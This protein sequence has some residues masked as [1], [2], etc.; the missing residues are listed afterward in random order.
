MRSV[1]PSSRATV[2]RACQGM[3]AALLA[4][5]ALPA[6]AQQPH[7]VQALDLPW[8]Q[9]VHKAARD[10]DYS[11]V[12]IYTQGQS[13]Q[14]MKLVHVVD[15]TGERERLEIMDGLPREFLRQNE[16]T[17][18]LLPEKKMVVI[19]RRQNERFPSFLVGDVSQLPQHYDMRRLPEQERVAGRPCDVVELVP[20]D[21]QR[22]GYRLC[23]DTDHRLLLRM[24]TVDATQSVVDQIAFASVSF[25]DQVALQDLR[26]SWNASQWQVVEPEVRQ[27]QAS[28]QGWV[29]TMPP[30]FTMHSEMLRPMRAGRQVTHLVMAD[31]LAAIS[32]FLERVGAPEAEE[33][34]L[35][36]YHRGAMNMF[37]TRIN[38]YVLTTT[39]EVPMPT[40]RALA[41]NTQFVSP[42]RTH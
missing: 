22:Y 1:Y 15:G 7:A 36:A 35:G 26:T 12:I 10:L 41:E 11:G 23:A 3:A 4:L 31:G 9:Q 34:S 25:G 2:V 18:C 29:F 28:E 30:G 37:R 16:V 19:E 38:D 40:L 33:N 6:T 32:V 42:S 13:S 27:I 14:S 39:G 20:K 21:T 24:Q 5:L 8:L 17:Q